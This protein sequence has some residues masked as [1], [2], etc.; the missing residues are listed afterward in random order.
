MASR[1]LFTQTFS[2]L[3]RFKKDEKHKKIYI[4]FAPES[5]S[6]AFQSCQASQSSLTSSCFGNLGSS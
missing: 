4:S 2:G 1:F 3:T 5:T 6:T